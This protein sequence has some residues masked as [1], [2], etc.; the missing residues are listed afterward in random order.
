MR[1]DE[2][3]ERNDAIIPVLLNLLV[4]C[5]AEVSCDSPTVLWGSAW[6]NTMTFDLSDYPCDGFNVTQ[7]KAWCA[8]YLF[9]LILFWF[10]AYGALGLD[11]QGSEH[12][13]GVKNTNVLKKFNKLLQLVA[14]KS[15][16]WTKVTKRGL[17]LRSKRILWAHLWSPWQQ[18]VSHES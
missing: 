14:T 12:Q 1:D 18:S 10:A 3:A 17:F 6:T 16:F 15:L 7:V 11:C 5:C 8:F 2:A 9:Y 13:M 4:S